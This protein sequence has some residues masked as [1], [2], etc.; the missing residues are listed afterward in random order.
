MKIRFSHILALGVTAGVA[1]WMWTGT[2]VEGGRADAANAT[3][4]P[5]ERQQEANA[6]A[7]RVSVTD[8]VAEPRQSTLIIRGRTEAEARVAVRAE[9]SGRVAERRVRE[10]QRIAKGDVM[11]VL[12]RG[13]REAQVME[14]K[15]QLA[16]AQL[17]HA[18]ASSLNEKGFAAQTR[19]AALKASL[20]AATARLKEQELELSRTIIEAP[21]AGIVES[22]MVETG[23]ILAIGHVCATL[24]NPDPVVAI[25]Q[26]SERQ[27]NAL[28]IGQS[29]TVA[30][31]GEDEVASGEVRYIALAADPATRTF[32]VEIEI[33][34]PDGAIRDGVTATARVPLSSGLAHR[35]SAGILT[36][37]DDG[38]VGIRAVDAQNRVT[39]HPVDILGGDTKGLWVSGLPERLTAIVVGQDYV[40]EGQTVE[41]VR[42]TVEAAS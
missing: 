9:T 2:Y 5:A 22:P 29:A 40:I 21:I 24:I 1:G 39:F 35:I 26:V 34:N 41:P 15:A 8:L 37:A 11:C 32:R 10:G 28:K 36:L 6:Q 30:L 16:Q 17:D 19:V 31:V 20:D 25:G 33:R 38:T 14:A 7:F 23:T 27:V 3:P 13:A 12:D 18:A 42:A 4:P